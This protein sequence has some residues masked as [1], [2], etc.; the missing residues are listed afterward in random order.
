MCSLSWVNLKNTI[1][2]KV[3][4][5]CPAVFVDQSTNLKS[6]LPV[7]CQTH[8]AVGKKKFWRKENGVYKIVPMPIFYGLVKYNLTNLMLAWTSKQTDTTA[9]CRTAFFSFFFK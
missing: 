9:P 2:S 5:K 1:C 8:F 6:S 7:A 4:L 3:E